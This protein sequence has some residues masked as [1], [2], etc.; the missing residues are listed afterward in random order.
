MPLWATTTPPRS[1]QDL[2][3]AVELYIKIDEL[4]KAYG[5]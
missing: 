1:D 2:Y 3:K 5:L 4:E